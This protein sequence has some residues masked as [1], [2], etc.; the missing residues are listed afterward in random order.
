MAHL[1]GDFISSVVRHQSTYH[2]ERSVDPRRD[3][4]GGEDTEASQTQSGTLDD[5]FA[6]VVA[7][8]ETHAS[9]ASTRR[10]TTV[11]R[12]LEWRWKSSGRTLA[13]LVFFE[14]LAA[15][16]VRVVIFVLAQLE[17]KIVDHVSLLNDIDTLGHLTLDSF[18]AENFHLG[19]EVWVSGGC[20]ATQ[21]AG[22]GE[23]ERASA[24]G[25]EGALAGWIL[26]LQSSKGLDDLQ[27]LAFG[28]DDGLV[29]AAGHDE[30]VNLGETLHG[31]FVGDV[32]AE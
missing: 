28:L 20:E 31:F 27:W 10:T 8:L 25:H 12:L 29:V 11:R 6:T 13:A 18:G 5:A 30:Y 22:F 15:Q 19:D 1:A 32:G 23:D 4:T 21:Y 14:L 17:A 9:L 26:H 24:D 3:T 16:D 7:H 2:V